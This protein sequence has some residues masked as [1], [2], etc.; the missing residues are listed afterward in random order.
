MKQE[1]RINPI[2]RFRRRY[3]GHLFHIWAEEYVV[4]I[5]R[6][7]PSF[8]GMLIRY[9]LYRLLFKE[10]KSFAL[11]YPGVYLTHTYGIKVGH[12]FSINSGTIIDGRGGITIGDDVMIGPHA[13]IYSSSHDTTQLDRPMTGLDHILKPVLIEDNVWIGA[14]TSILGGI[15]IGKGAIVAAGAVVV[16]DV[17]NNCIVAGVPARITGKRVPLALKR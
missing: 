7:L 13:V 1:E 10:I 15:V 3:S 14:H 8:E 17:A 2:A 9:S 16:D 4:W 12:R 11:I 5:T 6:N